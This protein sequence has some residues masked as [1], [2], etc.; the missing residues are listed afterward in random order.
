MPYCDYIELPEK[1]FTFCKQGFTVVLQTVAVLHDQ[2]STVKEGIG[3]L[4]A[5]NKA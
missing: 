5:N 2:E 4:S 1:Q 3:V